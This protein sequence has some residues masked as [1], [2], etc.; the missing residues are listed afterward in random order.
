MVKVDPAYPIE[1]SIEE[2]IS[3]DTD[4]DEVEVYFSGTKM[5]NQRLFARGGR[6]LGL[7]L[8][9][10]DL[11]TARD[12]IYKKLDVAKFDKEDYREDIGW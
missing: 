5:K 8:L 9:E 12:K 6:I 2:E 7:S 11:E 1:K 10:K 3:L 4:Q